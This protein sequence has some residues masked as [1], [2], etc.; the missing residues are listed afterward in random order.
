MDISLKDVAELLQK[1]TDKRCLLCKIFLVPI[2][3]GQ[4]LIRQGFDITSDP[5]PEGTY[6]YSAIAYHLQGIGIYCSPETLRHEVVSYLINNPAFGGT[7]F[8]PNFLD[9]D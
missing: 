4:K 5:S 7:N 8:F 9:M 6:Q 1:Q 3:N 2:T